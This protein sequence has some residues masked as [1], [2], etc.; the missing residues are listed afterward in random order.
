MGRRADRFN[1]FDADGNGALSVDEMAN[2]VTTI[3]KFDPDDAL[4]L[5]SMDTSMIA[6]MMMM[7][8]D[9]D[10]DGTISKDEFMDACGRNGMLSNVLGEVGRGRKSY[11]NNREV[12]VANVPFVQLCRRKPPLCCV[13]RCYFTP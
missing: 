8:F 1:M 11:V 12:C 10:G 13:C 9:T 4:D 3:S 2:V 6:E 7:D 5:G